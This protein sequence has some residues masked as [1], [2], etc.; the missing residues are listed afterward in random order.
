MK[1]L[2]VLFA[3]LVLSSTALAQTQ[4]TGLVSPTYPI[5]VDL[6]R[7]GVPEMAS[8]SRIVP[9]RTD[10][11]HISVPNPWDPVPDGSNT[12]LLENLTNGS[13]TGASRSL[14]A[15]QRIAIQA[16]AGDGTPTFFSFEELDSHPDAGTGQLVDGNAD[17]IWDA[18]RFTG[19]P[20]TFTL[21]FIFVDTSGDGFG[22]FISFPWASMSALGVDFG[23]GHN[24]PGPGTTDPQVWVPL[25][26]T[27]GDGRGDGIGV[28]LD[29][30]GFPDSDLPFGERFGPVSAPATSLA[31]AIPTAGEWGL[32]FVTLMIATAGVWHLRRVVA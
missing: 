24:I 17:N 28:D 25:A 12:F 31:L 18:M 19:G 5:L 6:D 14:P 27:N 23:D 21:P 20:T 22:D 15:V 3:A 1:K 13:F 7:D 2:A 4:M 16:Y 11:T 32:L 29:N 9:I 10:S 26:D 30:N 8:D